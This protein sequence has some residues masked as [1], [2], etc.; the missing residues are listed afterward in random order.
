MEN[1]GAI[2][3]FEPALLVD[4]RLSSQS[5]RQWVFVTVVHEMAHQWFGKLVTMDWWDDLWLNEGYATWME[6]KVESA[7]HPSA[8]PRSRS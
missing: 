1:W 4:P 3:Y 7:L 5:D 6:L 2:L 8:S